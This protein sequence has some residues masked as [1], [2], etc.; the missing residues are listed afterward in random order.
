M[1]NPINIRSKI[2]S[3]TSPSPGQAHRGDRGRQRLLTALALLVS[4]LYFP[5]LVL[6]P[7]A[8]VVIVIFLIGTWLR[9]F[10]SFTIMNGWVCL[11]ASIAF[12]LLHISR[13]YLDRKLEETQ[14]D[15]QDVNV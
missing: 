1:R 2:S 14:T 6:G 11:V 3:A 5:A 4:I 13:K 10:E 12:V 7:V 9:F 15:V 8:M